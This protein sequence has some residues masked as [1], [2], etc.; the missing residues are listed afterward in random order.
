MGSVNRFFVGLKV[1]FKDIKA[2]HLVAIHSFFIA[3][4]LNDFVHLVV[5]LY[6]G[7]SI[8]FFLVANSCLFISST[9]FL[10]VT[11]F[12]IAKIMRRYNR[13]EWRSFI[14]LLYWV[15]FIISTDDIEYLIKNL[16]DNETVIN[17]I[18]VI[19]VATGVM[20]WLLSVYFTIKAHRRKRNL[21][22][23]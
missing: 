21:K 11:P 8:S 12:T 10:I 3:A 17:I 13:D 20:F 9:G 4:T 2:V 18:M 14:F 5:F 23:H 19:V 1:V 15:L 16:Y 6:S 7:I 22:Q